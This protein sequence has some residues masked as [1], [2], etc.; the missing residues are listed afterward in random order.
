VTRRRFLAREASDVSSKPI[1]ILTGP[2]VAARRAELAD[3]GLL[4]LRIAVG[5]LMLGSHGWAK[6]SSYGTMAGQFPD[7]IGLG[8][9]PS[10]IL[11]IFAEF[12]CSLALILGLATRW[13]TIPLIVTMLVA[14][15][16]VHADDPWSKKEFALLYL[17]PLV[18]LLVAGPGRFAL[19]DVLRRTAA[20]SEA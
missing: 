7:P 5:A 20:G 1:E 18:T 6:L 2:A 8:S 9:T 4:I 3:W 16:V 15:L 13:A 19:D 11:A 14:V 10:L 12:F 17:V